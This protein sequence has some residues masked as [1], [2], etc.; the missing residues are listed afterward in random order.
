MQILCK[1]RCCDVGEVKASVRVFFPVVFPR[2][3]TKRSLVIA[4]PRFLRYVKI[5]QSVCEDY[6]CILYGCESAFASHPSRSFA[7]SPGLECEQDKIKSNQLRRLHFREV[8][9]FS[10]SIAAGGGHGASRELTDEAVR[11]QRCQTGG[12]E[13]SHSA[14]LSLITRVPSVSPSIF[15]FFLHFPL[16]MCP[17]L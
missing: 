3:F 7:G 16:I 1:F 6:Y 4:R 11:S 2:R 9:T 15:F 12:G 10:A 5:S 14:S 13:S 17:S 8:T